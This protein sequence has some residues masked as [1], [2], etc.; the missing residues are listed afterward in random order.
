MHLDRIHLVNFKNFQDQTFDFS[1]KINAFVGNNGVGK[2]NVLDAVYYLSIFKSYFHHS[3][4]NNIKFDEDYFFLEGWFQKEEQ[5]EHIQCGFQIGQK[6]SVKRNQ[7]SYDRISD[8]IG[9][10]PV[11]IISPYD[12]DLIAEG[13]DVR[14]KFLDSIISQ[15]NA[16]YLKKLIRYNKVL[17]QRNS[18]LKYFAANRVFDALQLEVFDNEILSLGAYIFEERDKF[19]QEFHPVF[20]YYY[21]AISTGR[22]EVGVLYASDLKYN[23]K[24]YLTDSLD[25]DKLLQYTTAGIHKDDL[26]FIINQNK[27]KKFGSQG[28]QKSFLIALKLA[29]LDF[30]KNHLNITPILLLDDIFDKLDESRV[31]QLIKLVNDADFGQI[32]IS[33]TH[34]ERTEELLKRVNEDYK[35]FKL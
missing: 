2:T 22:E 5:E 17:Q 4:K 28:Q 9:K 1:P 11:V 13:S 16:T 10:F 24:N 35:L 30:I 6:K 15:A 12:R 34:P 19:I 26:D 23:Q 14:R 3:D 7:K 31:E 27:I 18:L 25:R 32:F 33:D 20:Q 8:H 21:N 29:Q